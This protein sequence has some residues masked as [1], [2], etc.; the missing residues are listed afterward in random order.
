MPPSNPIAMRVVVAAGFAAATAAVTGAAN[1]E[2]AATDKP[3]SSLS[4]VRLPGAEGCLSAADLG[5]RVEEK[6]G[7]AALVSASAAERSVEARAERL[8]SGRFR[9]I[10]TGSRRDGTTLGSRELEGAT[11]KGL[12]DGLV[13]VIAL[14]IDPDAFAAPRPEPVAPVPPVPAPPTVIVQERVVIR[15]VPVVVPAEARPSDMRS[16]DAR[17]S[18]GAAFGRGPCL[19][20][21]AVSRDASA[22]GRERTGPEAGFLV[23]GGLRIPAGRRLAVSVGADGAFA[24]SVT[25]VAGTLALCA[26]TPLVGR[27]RGGLCGGLRG[28]AYFAQGSGFSSNRAAADGLFDATLAPE[29]TLPVAG[30]AFVAVA[31]GL[32]APLVRQ[33]LVVA[34]PNGAVTPVYTRPAIGGEVLVG[35]GFAFASSERRP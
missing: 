33:R 32:S 22:G 35:V 5:G 15:E 9:V 30:R 12:E 18:V 10:V 17:L 8:P 21:P 6:L 29:L 28:G 23:A 31:A 4:W 34:G 20:G 27:L 13:L 7:R 3:T 2:P 19:C 26:E 14:M 25:T 16:V 1:A 24:G 11:C